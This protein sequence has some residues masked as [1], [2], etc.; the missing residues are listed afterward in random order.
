M[1]DPISLH[2]HSGGKP[3]ENASDRAIAELASRQHGVI[4]RRQLITLGLGEDAIAYRLKRHRL[5]PLHR[6]VYAVGHHAVTRQAL[7]M[8]AVMAGGP[9]AVLSHWSAAALWGLAT[10]SSSVSH[11]TIPSG[12]APRRTIR[13]HRAALPSDEVTV[14]DGIPVTTV[15]RTLLDMAATTDVRG[16]ERAQHEA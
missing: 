3:R 4:A 5:H 1:T 7:W 11:V 12:K 9:A 6:G 15:P 2:R 13:F 14:R 10:D 16:L 8:A